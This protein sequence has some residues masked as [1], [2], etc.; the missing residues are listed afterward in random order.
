MYNFTFE[1]SFF[2]IIDEIARLWFPRILL[3]TELSHF[4]EYIVWKMFYEGIKLYVYVGKHGVAERT[5]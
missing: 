4:S 3:E 1:K 2:Q 5:L